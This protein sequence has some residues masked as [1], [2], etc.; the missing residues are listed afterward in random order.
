MIESAEAM[1]KEETHSHFD[2]NNIGHNDQS[3][4]TYL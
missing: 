2:N 1:K 3:V 4:Q